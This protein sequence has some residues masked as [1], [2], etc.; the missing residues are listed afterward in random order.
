MTDD[1][2]FRNEAR[3]RADCSRREFVMFEWG[4]GWFWWLAKCDKNRLTLKRAALA[5]SS[6][7]K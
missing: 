2:L 5:Y 4:D 6:G 7:F 3:K 1:A